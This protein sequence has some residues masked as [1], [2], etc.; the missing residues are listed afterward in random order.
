MAFAFGETVTLITRTVTGTDAF[1]TDVYT[2]VETAWPGTVFA[3]AGSAGRGASVEAG[4]GVVQLV[5][6]RASFTWKDELPDLSSVDAI[7]RPNGDVYELSGEPDEYPPVMS[8]TQIL[9]AHADKK[10]G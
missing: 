7:R 6:T 2:T 5:D 3:P 9:Q 4:T 10:T 8:A 1:G